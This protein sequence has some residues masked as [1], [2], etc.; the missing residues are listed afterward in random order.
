MSYYKTNTML[1]E[2]S[3]KTYIAE[4]CECTELILNASRALPLDLRGSTLYTAL[5]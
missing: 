1:R 3:V 2:L 4:L 5:T